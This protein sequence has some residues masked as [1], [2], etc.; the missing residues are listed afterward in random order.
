MIL[1]IESICRVNHSHTFFVTIEK[2]DPSPQI[3]NHGLSF[4]A[5]Q[6]PAQIPLTQ[7]LEPP[8]PSALNPQ[9]S[10]LPDHQVPQSNPAPAA[11][12]PAGLD[13]AALQVIDQQYE[14]YR[15][16]FVESSMSA[17]SASLLPPAFPGLQNSNSRSNLGD[18]GA[19]AANLNMPINF[20]NAP[21]L[22]E[23]QRLELSNK[24]DTQLLGDQIRDRKR[25]L[26]SQNDGEQY[27]YYYHNDHL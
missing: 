5:P 11:S 25:Q 4:Q 15:R 26:E 18:S 6:H 24:A 20:L 19:N 1:T 10:T 16:T 22:N 13:L 27:Q 9:L 23:R 8:I 2:T 14:N 3:N 7:H 17:I 21:N 12:G